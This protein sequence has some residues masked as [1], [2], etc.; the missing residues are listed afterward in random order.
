MWRRQ[1]LTAPPDLLWSQTMITM[2]RRLSIPDARWWERRS[3]S[4]GLS[5]YL[6]RPVEAG[7]G[8]DWDW[9][10][11]RMTWFK[12]QRNKVHQSRLRFQKFW[13]KSS[14]RLNFR[15]QRKSWYKWSLSSILSLLGIEDGFRKIWEETVH[16][17]GI[18]W[19][20]SIILWTCSSK[21]S[22]NTSWILSIKWM[23][24]IQR[25]TTTLPCWCQT[26]L[27]QKR[28]GPKN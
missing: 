22:L 28:W 26:Q 17:V 2:S 23:V 13:M 1:W 8:R 3:N 12:K 20:C 11:Q 6:G 9:Y 16:K 27:F 14:L 24:E 19:T 4:S 10:I 21:K 25:E 18:L 7:P 5:R 15:K